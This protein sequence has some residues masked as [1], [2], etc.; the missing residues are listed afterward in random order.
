MLITDYT[1]YEDIRT[2]VGLSSDEL[3]DAL[4]DYEI[5]ANVLQLSLRKVSLPSTSPGTGTLD[6]QFIVIADKDETARTVLEQE[7]YN[8]TR[9]F[10]TYTVALEVAV[11][12]GTRTPK[13]ESDGKRTISRFSPEATFQ[14]TVAAIRK[15]IGDVRLKLENIG[16][17][18]TTVLPLLSVITPAVNVV[19]NE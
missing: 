2:T 14:D 12:L 10:S 8:L 1:S 18:D 17:T 3:P 6:A 13:T 4:L 15:V 11:S 16:A 19:T 9:I 7:L 5:Y